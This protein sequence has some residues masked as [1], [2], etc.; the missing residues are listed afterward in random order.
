MLAARPS[1]PSI[2]LKAL[3]ANTMAKTARSECK[4]AKSDDPNVSW[5][6]P[7]LEITRFSPITTIVAAAIWK[8]NFMIAGTGCLSSTTPKI[9][10]IVPAIIPAQGG[11]GIKNKSPI[12]TTSQI[13]GPPIRG[14]SPLCCLRPVGL[15]TRPQRLA[16]G[17]RAITSAVVSNVAITEM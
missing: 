9:T 1:M 3:M 5:K 13:T 12:I 16:R 4:V 17:I 15:S 6:M 7:I 2:I 8:M 10:S 14:I 11:F